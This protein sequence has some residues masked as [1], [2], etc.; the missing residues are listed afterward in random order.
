[1]PFAAGMAAAVYLPPGPLYRALAF[2]A[3]LALLAVASFLSKYPR[4]T[5]C[6][7]PRRRLRAALLA[8]AAGA[9]LCLGAVSHGRAESVAMRF[10]PGLSPSSGLRAAAYEGVVAADPRLTASG[11][12]ALELELTA[13]VGADG[14][15][16]TAS[17][18]LSVYARA[19]APALSERVVRGQRVVVAVPRGLREPRAG[20][21]AWTDALASRSVFVAAADVA[22][23]GPAP[24]LEALRAV[25]RRGMLAGLARAGGEAGPLLEALVVG[26]R[27]DL[28]LALADDFRRAGCAHILA[29]SGQHV[30]ILAAFVSVLLG[31]ALGPFRARAAAC[32]LA[33]AYLYVVGASPSVARAVLM[34]WLSSAASAADRPQ[35]PLA[36]LSAAFAAAV[37]LRP[38]TAYALSFKL[39]YLAVAGL[40]VLGPCFELSLRRWVPPPESGAVAA[41]FAALAATAPLSVAAFGALNPFSPLTSAVAGLLV[42]ALM[43]AGIAGSLVVAVLP[44]AAPL[45]ALACALPY[46][47]LRSLMGLAAGL[48]SL[49]A[50]DPQARALLAGVV[51]LAAAFVYAWPHVAYH[52]ESRRRSP[53]GQLRLPLGPVL[54]ARGPRPR[55]AQEVRPELPRVRPRQAPHRRPLRVRPRP[56][57]LG[58][59]AGHRLDDP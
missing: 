46:R 43:W 37:A 33:A 39:S 54:P 15:R 44:F 50:D 26:V 4:S 10:C 29:L 8:A 2:S 41:G 53:A 12:T 21:G 56:A 42:A 52:A 5:I 22:M 35:S 59:R 19:G 40:A 31:F 11:M 38:E 47:A 58:D 27:D 9:G 32:A 30:G 13:A 48:P 36:V 6:P 18:R 3:A 55:D 14:A 16:A 28:D 34:F 17:G 57:R 20:L 24:P 23:A 51:A 1:M 49:S 7:Y 45:V 25:V